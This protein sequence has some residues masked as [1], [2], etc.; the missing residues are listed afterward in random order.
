MIPERREEY[1]RGEKRR[2][3]AIPPPAP[4]RED[5]PGVLFWGKEERR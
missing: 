4:G 3:S 1:K 5:L 2:L